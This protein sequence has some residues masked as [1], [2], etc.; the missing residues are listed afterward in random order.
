M[1]SWFIVH[2]QPLEKYPPV[3]N[4]IRFVQGQPDFKNDLQVISTHPGKETIN[5]SNVPVHRVVKWGKRSR[6]QRLFFYASF[7]LRSL[8]LLIRHRPEK[9]LYYE[10]LSAFGPWFYKKYIN[11]KAELYIHYHEYI[12]SKEYEQGMVM[13]RRLHEKEKQLYPVAS[14]ISHTN[15]D[16]MQLFLKDI[17]SRYNYTYI[18]PNYPSASWKEKAAAVERNKGGRIA[19]VYV[20]A[21]SLSTMHTREMAEFVARHQDEC[22]WDIYSDNHNEEVIAFLKTL[23]APNIHFK[24]AVAYDDLPLV[25]PKY[26][27]GVILYNG[28]TPNY[29]YNAPNKFF[30]YYICGL[31][32]WFGQG[33]KGMIP[34]IKA[35]SKP[36]VEL[37]NFDHLTIPVRE[38]AVRIEHLPEAAYTAENVYLSLWKC[39]KG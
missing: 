11:S 21:L 8:F 17:G 24:G 5:F 3:I 25:L 27:V 34:Y 22:F 18:M 29:E 28:N 7:N 2:F 23:N 26:D 31:N 36:V 4:F 6:I 38:R 9:V 32:V 33:M 19:F 30:E 15:N 12:S 1:R 16:R 14:W 10:T 39:L 20:G 35:D 13:T 37:V